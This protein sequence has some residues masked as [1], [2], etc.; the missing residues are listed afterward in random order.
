MRPRP[1]PLAIAAS[2]LL[3]GCA[4]DGRD[5]DA[6][7][8]PGDPADGHDA[9]HGALGNFTLAS[10]DCLEGGGHSVHPELPD[11][12]PEPWDPADVMEDTGKPP[13]YTEAPFHPQYVVPQDGNSMGNWHVAVTCGS[14]AFNGRDLAEHVFGYVGMRVEP[15]PFDEGP[16]ADRHYLVTVISSNDGAVREALHHA[17]FHATDATGWA[18][19]R[20][21]GVFHSI[22]D[23]DGHGVYESYFMPMPGGDMPGRFRL[24]FQMEN[25]NGTFSPV[26]LDVENTGGE[27]LRA[28][29][30]GT[31]THLETEDHAPLPGAGGESP[32]V[33]YTG[34]SR[35][36]TLGPRPSVYLE[37]AY[38][39]S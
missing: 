17:G 26:A 19:V 24:W 18:V 32:Q 25:G 20:D 14:D 11:Y 5:D 28:D 39:H 15:P 36:M 4:S 22:L 13:V 10:T 27:R 1:W 33:A 16:P 3:A 21:D 31:F 6:H 7:K 37:E 34:F 23:T 30:Y 29:P 38:V 35:T 9:T 12:L 8:H 2:I